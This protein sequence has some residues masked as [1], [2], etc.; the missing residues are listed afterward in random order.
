MRERRKF[1]RFSVGFPVT[2]EVLEE[3]RKARPEEINLLT[4]DVCAGG[5]YLDTP[6]PLPEGTSVHMDILLKLDGQKEIEENRAHLKID[7][8]VLRAEQAGRN[9]RPL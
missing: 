9:G 1:E 7:G 6:A 3:D 8:W 5:A 4:R 2:L